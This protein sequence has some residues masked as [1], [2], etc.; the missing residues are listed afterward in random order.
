MSRF[1]HP[2]L[3][4]VAAA[5]IANTMACGPSPQP[6]PPPAEVILQGLS[7]AEG[8]EPNTVRLQGGPSATKNA[9]TVELVSIGS[10]SALYDVETIQVATDG[11]FDAQL[12]GTTADQFRMQAFGPGGAAAPLDLVLGGSGP[13]APDRIDCLTL[14]VASEVELPPVK[15]GVE[16]D[17]E[18]VIESSCGEPVGIDDVYFVIDD[19]W[20]SNGNELGIPTDLG[21][22]MELVLRV[23]TT[24]TSTGPSSNFVVLR[25]GLATAEEHRV[26][27]LRTHGL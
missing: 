15:V 10:A 13:E 11:S 23:S 3:L 4:L 8:D 1:S 5:L 20:G 6:L 26:V 21:N 27:T 14:D 24:P 7:I 9:N 19:G 16:T 2:A 25:L 17:L 22:G 12:T 18:L